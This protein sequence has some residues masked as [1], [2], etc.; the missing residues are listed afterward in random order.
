M[1]ELKL[2]IGEKTFKAK[3]APHAVSF[4]LFSPD[5]LLVLTVDKNMLALD[6]TFN[7]VLKPG[8]DIRYALALALAIDD[9]FFH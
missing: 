9:V 8:F 2:E 5:G 7:I 6:D 3:G 4:E 1:P